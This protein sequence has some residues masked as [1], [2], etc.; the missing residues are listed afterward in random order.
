MGAFDEAENVID[1][2]DVKK[3]FKVYYDRGVA[4]KDRFLNKG[5][6][7]YELRQVLKGVTFQ[8]KKGEAIGLIGKNGCGKSTTLKLLTKIMYPDEGTI[9]MKGRV[10]SLLELGAGFHP[11][12]SGRENIYMNAAI[13]GLTKKEINKRVDDIIAFSELQEFIENPVRTYSSGM[14][15]RLAFSVAINVNADILL[16]DEILAVGDINFQRKCFDRLK[17]I[18]RQGTTIVI[19]SHSFDQIEKICDRSVWIKDGVVKEEGIPKVVHKHYLDYMEEERIERMVAERDALEKKMALEDAEKEALEADEDR[20][21]NADGT[22]VEGANDGTAVG[23]GDGAIDGT[24]DGTVEGAGDGTADGTTPG[25]GEGTEADGNSA[26]AVEPEPEES[27]EEIAMRQVEERILEI[28]KNPN[29]MDSLDKDVLRR[30]D[31]SK[32]ELTRVNIVN[33]EN[34]QDQV[35]RTGDEVTVLAEFKAHEKYKNGTLSMSFYR[36]DGVYCFGTNTFIEKQK[37][38]NLSE[39]KA[40][41][42]KIP[43]CNLLPGKYRITVGMHDDIK[44]D[45]YDQVDKAFPIEMVDLKGDLGICRLPVECTFVEKKDKKSKET[46]QEK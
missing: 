10:S 36:E 27:P 32:V 39:G 21:E 37:I 6:S 4:I 11:D 42:M 16:I 18:K 41:L 7:H 23:A 29:L 44:A 13:F 5:K 38:M 30:G 14:Y 2:C 34:K 31:H 9:T 12:M 26:E 19:V 20:D 8:V 40:V 15:M 35:F 17:D 28:R 24:T 33:W 22:S 46:N 25:T 3:A 43:V 1:V 45:F